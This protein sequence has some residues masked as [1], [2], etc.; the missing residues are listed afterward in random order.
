M[1]NSPLIS[2]CV[3][4]FNSV[5]TIVETLNSIYDQSYDNLELIISDDFSTDDTIEI[6]RDW[7]KKYADRFTNIQ[8]L[9]TD[10]NSGTTANF[11][12][13]CRAATGEW[14]KPIAGDD[15]LKPFAIGRYLDFCK[16]NGVAVCASCLDFFGDND[17][18]EAKK[19]SYLNF[20]NKYKDLSRE[21]KYKLLL[22]ECVLPMPGMFI[23]KQ[24]LEFINYADESYAFAEEWPLYM[25]IFDA[26]FDIPYFEDKLVKY[27]NEVNCLSSG[28]KYS[29]SKQG[30]IYQRASEKVFMSNYKFYKE[31]RRPRLLKKM[32]IY[33]VWRAD[34]SYEIQASHYITKPSVLF[35]IRIML[36]RIMNPAS[37]KALYIYVCRMFKTRVI[38]PQSSS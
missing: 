26:G 10:H 11:N 7:L 22:Y 37:Y 1:E 31:Y 35:K 25:K 28:G 2:V 19:P 6:C 12:R 18:I 38:S 15:L 33:K 32:K 8:I 3:I 23:S 4:V 17:I 36:L 21:E 16:N 34:L 5:R 30:L 20:Y 9:T 29:N 13:G 14:I 27:R 24:L